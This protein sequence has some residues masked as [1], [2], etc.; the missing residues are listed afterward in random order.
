[1]TCD[2]DRDTAQGAVGQCR[3]REAKAASSPPH[4]VS[5]GSIHVPRFRHCFLGTRRLMSREKPGGHLGRW[6]GAATT[7]AGGI[8]KAQGDGSTGILEGQQRELGSF[9]L[10]AHL[11]VH[12]HSA[13]VVCVRLPPPPAHVWSCDSTMQSRTSHPRGLSGWFSGEQLAGPTQRRELVSVRVT[14]RSCWPGRYTD[15]I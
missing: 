2:A 9:L 15:E 5:M 8:S 1:M 6:E 11:E 7:S 10:Q 13:C 3:R 12:P 4:I 14:L